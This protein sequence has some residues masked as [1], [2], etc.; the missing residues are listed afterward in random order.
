MRPKRSRFV[1][2][3]V[4]IGIGS[5]SCAWHSFAAVLYDTCAGQAGSGQPVGKTVGDPPRSPLKAT[6]SVARLT[7]TVKLGGTGQP[8]AG[9]KLQILSGFFLG[10]GIG[11]TRRKDRSDRR[12][13][14]VLCRSTGR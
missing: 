10:L 8:I 2:V 7:G 4:L 13:W 11:K 3:L 6:T 5:G 12:G 9:A 14:P 1:V